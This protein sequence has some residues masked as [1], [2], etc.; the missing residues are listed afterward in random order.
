MQRSMEIEGSADR[1]SVALQRDGGPA[2]SA[3]RH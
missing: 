1:G 3:R 2:S